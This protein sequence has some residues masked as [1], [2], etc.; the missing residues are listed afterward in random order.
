MYGA[1]FLLCLNGDSKY[2]YLQSEED[3]NMQLVANYEAEDYEYMPPVPGDWANL[4]SDLE[5]E[6][7][8]VIDS[9]PKVYLHFNR[10]IFINYVGQRKLYLN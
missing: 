8:W 2:Q 4:A 3:S 9:R 1:N 7:D 5:I 10:R 6:Q